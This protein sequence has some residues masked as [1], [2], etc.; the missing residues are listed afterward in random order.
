MAK[1]G[2][3]FDTVPGGSHAPAAE[4]G[5]FLANVSRV[6]DGLVIFFDVLA[7]NQVLCTGLPAIW[8][9]PSVDR[10]LKLF[11]VENDPMR[12]FAGI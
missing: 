2:V 6:V 8:R 7:R 1:T 3:G 9:I 4:I 12:Q 10:V 11:R 5:C